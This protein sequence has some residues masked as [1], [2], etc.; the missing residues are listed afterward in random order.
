M[1]DQVAVYFGGERAESLL[2][3]LIALVAIEVAVTCWRKSGT[4]VAK[5]AA[6]MLVLV[7]VVQL[8]VGG[9]VFLRSPHDQQRVAAAVAT[10]RAQ[11][12]TNEV[13]RM[14]R[15][16]RDFAVYRWVEI[17]LL[18]LAT[19]MALIDRRS[20]WV[21]G[22]GLGLLPQAAVMLVLDGLAEHR[23]AAYLVW[24]LTL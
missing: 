24:L 20:T 13:P 15:V 7:A 1:I 18:I 12:R 17:A 19:M 23:G 16:M 6:V 10:D 21:R 3:I 4:P 9:T 22:A 14:Q 2:F 11:I 5:G 8:G